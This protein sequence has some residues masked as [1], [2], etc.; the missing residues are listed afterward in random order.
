MSDDDFETLKRLYVNVHRAWLVINAA[1]ARS[2]NV[3]IEANRDLD[4]LILLAADGPQGAR[5][6]LDQTAPSGTT[7]DSLRRLAVLG[8]VRDRNGGRP[9]DST[10][11]LELTDRGREALQTTVAAIVAGFVD[12][13]EF[14]LK[15]LADGQD[16]KQN[17]DIAGA[18]HRADVTVIRDL[19]RFG[20]RLVSGAPATPFDAGYAGT[21]IAAMCMADDT[22][23]LTLTDLADFC[24]FAV[25]RV[26]T[27]VTWLA[28]QGLVD[29]HGT[30]GGLSADGRQIL[31][32][33]LATKVE[34]IPEIK[35]LLG[36]LLQF[37]QE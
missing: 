32:D 27:V 28:Q 2:G 9:T 20:R 6:L 14:F 21:I 19:A 36:N 12:A 16:G 3:L 34:M 23:G 37:S 31:C 24:G 17:P 29:L 22:P 26:E 8:M 5:I 11:V 33:F 30:S 10:A 25:Q 1:V 13:R 15:A 7:M 18:T 4:P 35:G